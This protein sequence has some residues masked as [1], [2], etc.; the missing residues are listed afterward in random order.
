[1]RCFLSLQL[2]LPFLFTLI[3]ALHSTPSFANP[4][5]SRQLVPSIHHDFQLETIFGTH[6]RT[7]FSSH[8]KRLLKRTLPGPYYIGPASGSSSAFWRVTLVAISPFIPTMDAARDLDNLYQGIMSYAQDF[9]N[10]GAETWNSFAFRRGAVSLVMSFLDDETGIP[11]Q[12]VYDL[13]QSFLE[14][15]RMGHV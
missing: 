3:T 11:W 15:S 12:L 10:S 14:Q 7:S 5:S 9:I 13:A 8:N 4:A 1:M 2:S 6:R